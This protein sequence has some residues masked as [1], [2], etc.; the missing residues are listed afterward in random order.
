MAAWLPARV[1]RGF[2]ELWCEELA[3]VAALAHLRRRLRTATTGRPTVEHPD[4]EHWSERLVLVADEL[5]SNALRHGGGPVQTA[6]SRVG[7]QWMVSV[8]DYSPDVPPVPAQ[9]RDPGLGG[10]GLYLIADLAVRHGWFT[11]HGMKTVWAVV[12]AD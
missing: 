4:R 3:S 2:A 12:A 9:G 6:L 7:D 5:T 8:S 11:A 1:P 10:L